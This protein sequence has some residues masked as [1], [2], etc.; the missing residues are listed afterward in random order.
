MVVKVIAGITL[1]LS[2]GACSGADANDS[3]KHVAEAG[4]IDSGTRVDATLQGAL[5]SRTDSAGTMLR[6]ITSHDVKDGLGGVAIPAGADVSLI[7]GQ[8][9]AAA[10][11]TSPDG[12]LSLRTASVM[13]NGK[14]HALS[15]DIATVPHHLEW[16]TAPRGD[17]L[18]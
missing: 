8:I 3:P 5:S 2:I 12:A 10:D 1:A 15:A 9:S 13:V 11:A 18:R 17:V 7:V 16:R 4:V 14:A 6:A